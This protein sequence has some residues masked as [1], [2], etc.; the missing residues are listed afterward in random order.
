[1]A[2][3]PGVVDP[4]LR[5]LFIFDVVVSLV[6]VGEVFGL[7]IDPFTVLVHHE[8]HAVFLVGDMAVLVINNKTAK[9]IISPRGALIIGF[10]FG[11]YAGGGGEGEDGEDKDG[12]LHF[13]CY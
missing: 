10:G 3:S 13:K 12:G 4:E 5:L 6:V 9:A 7:A 2:I 1:M 11:A 8:S